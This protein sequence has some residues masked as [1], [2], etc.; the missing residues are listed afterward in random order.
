MTS[1]DR[2]EFSDD[3]LTESHFWASIIDEFEWFGRIEDTTCSRLAMHPED[4]C[5]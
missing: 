2:S 4:K 3:V 1:E 5:W